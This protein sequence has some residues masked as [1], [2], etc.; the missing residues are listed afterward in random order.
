MM[1]PSQNK[2]IIAVLV[3]GWVAFTAQM[4]AS[5]ISWQQAQ[6]NVMDFMQQRGKHVAVPMLRH[7]SKALSADWYVFNIGDNDGYV[8]AAGDDLA[9]AI[10]GYADV[11]SVDINSIPENMQ[12]WLDEYAR[13]IQFMRDNHLFGPHKAMKSPAEPA[14]PPLLTSR[15][16]QG[17]PYNRYCPLDTN[18][19]RCPTGCVATAMAQMLYYHRINSVT[20]TT[21]E[22]PPFV[23]SNGVAVDAVPAGSVIDWGNMVDAYSNSD[24]TTEEQKDAVARLMLYC[25]SSVQMDYK[26]GSSA[27]YSARVAP[28]LIAFL[29]YSSRTKYRYRDNCGL[30]DEEWEDFIYHELSNSR[31]VYYSGV[32]ANSVAHAFVCDGYDGDGFFHINWGWGSSGG[33]YR[34]TAIDSVNTSVLNYRYYQE[35]VAFAEPRSS[36]PS[37]NVGIHFAD[38]FAWAVCLQSGDVNDDGALDLEE[39]L[40][41]TELE[42]FNWLRMAS[43]DEFKLFTG[44]TSMPVR[45]FEGCWYLASITLPDSLKTIGEYA[46]KDCQ[47][48]KQITIPESVAS[49]GI[50]LFSGCTSLKHII[51]NAKKCSPTVLPIVPSSIERLTIGDAVE[52]IPNNFAKNSYVKY[53]TIGNSVTKIG[54]SAFYQC[55]GL[56][57]VVIPNSVTVIA[58]S[59]FFEN[60][61]LESVIF[62]KSLANIGD[63]SFNNCRA[64]TEVSIPNSVTRIGMYAFNGCTSLASVTIGNSVNTISSRAFAGCDS[65]K[66]VTCLVPEPLAINANVFN[67]HLYGQAVLRVPM[68]A[69][70]AYRAASPWNQFS[71][72]VGIDPA[73]GDVNLDGRTD[74]ADVTDLINQLLTAAST[75]Y[76]DVNGDGMVNIADVTDLINKLLTNQ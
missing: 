35:V 14:V 56:K 41:V 15:W 65:L 1:K 73:D 75:E 33:Y 46:F 32:S 48:L 45:L 23:T 4:M 7:A 53:L 52:L 5:P 67:N 39:V 10:L 24:A 51:W 74:I 66:V 43:F 17:I 22:M 2:S 12:W 42:P 6:L 30:S 58:Q 59:A 76:G 31:P 18:G 64:L 29:N 40:A 27:A 28:A 20:E 26:A 3:T 25:G 47:S 72:I 70:D 57:R 21:H 36:L 11:G 55:A 69:V 13:Q 54:S 50:Q 63:R 19:V 62:G 8:I 34:L 38:P 71:E 37:P 9:P 68:N 61:G 60:T 16:N 49:V 44:V